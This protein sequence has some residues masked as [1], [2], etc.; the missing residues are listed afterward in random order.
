MLALRAFTGSVRPIASK[1]LSCADASTV[2][3]PLLMVLRRLA[4]AA[5]TAAKVGG[6]AALKL[7]TSSLIWVVWVLTAFRTPTIAVLSRAS[8]AGLY[9]VA[10]TP[11]VKA[12]TVVRNCILTSVR[13]SW[14]EKDCGV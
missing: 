13:V 9:T 1:A 8:T 12:R 7:F 3:M 5:S 14:R 4:V 10:V 6:S 11:A 2:V